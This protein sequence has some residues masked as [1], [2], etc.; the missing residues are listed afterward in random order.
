M[1]K[2]IF[3]KKSEKIGKNRKKSE[4]IRKNRK[5][6]EKIEKILSEII[7]KIINNTCIYVYM[8]YWQYLI[9]FGR[10]KKEDRR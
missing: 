3:L 7:R 1:P 6:S 9:K 10:G 8:T 5:K 4:K 2:R